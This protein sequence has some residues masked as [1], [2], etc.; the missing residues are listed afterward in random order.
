MI[1]E[2]NFLGLFKVNT[3]FPLVGKNNDVLTDSIPKL[4]LTNSLL[5]YVSKSKI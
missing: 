3:M 4:R 5:K 1:F 2:K